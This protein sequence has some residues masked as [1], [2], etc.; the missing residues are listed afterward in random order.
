MQNQ[1]LNSY[2][3]NLFN[4]YAAIFIFKQYRLYLAINYLGK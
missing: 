4:L 2:A 1:E 3:H